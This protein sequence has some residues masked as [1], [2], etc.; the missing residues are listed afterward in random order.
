[1]I[2]SPCGALQQDGSIVVGDC[3][4]D[5][6]DSNEENHKVKP[7]TYEIELTYTPQ[8]S[9]PVTVGKYTF[10]VQADGDSSTPMIPVESVSLNKK[11]LILK[12]GTSET[13]T[14]ILNPGTATN[15][16]VTWEKQ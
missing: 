11:Q 9:S 8:S 1:M 4:I 5:S 13:L 2:L 16:E 10:V 3:E 12:K 7:G 6:G 15:Q 14:A